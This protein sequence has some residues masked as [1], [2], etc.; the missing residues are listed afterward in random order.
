MVV[1][2]FPRFQYNGYW[3]GIADPRSQ[4]W[5][6]TGMEMASTMPTAAI[7]STTQAIQALAFQSASR[8]DGRAAVGGGTPA[9]TPTPAKTKKISN[10]P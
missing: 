1:G 8:C 6:I 5:A 4:Q 7:T 9:P 10:V 2:G 3:V